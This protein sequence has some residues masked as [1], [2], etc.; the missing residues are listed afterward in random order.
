M[1]K[2]TLKEIKKMFASEHVK[3]VMD[4]FGVK[5]YDKHTK[6]EISEYQALKILRGDY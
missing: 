4:L 3:I 2:T 1:Y 6:K 5:Y